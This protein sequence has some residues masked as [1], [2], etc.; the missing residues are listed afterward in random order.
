MRDKTYQLCQR[1]YL[2]TLGLAIGCVVA[3][4]VLLQIYITVNPILEWQRICLIVGGLIALLLIGVSIFA[5]P[6]TINA[7]VD[8]FKTGTLFEFLVIGV[9]FPLFAVVWV[10]RKLFFWKKAY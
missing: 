3:G 1:C 4:F 7:W 5:K 8:P 10:I 6:N 9:G 2:A